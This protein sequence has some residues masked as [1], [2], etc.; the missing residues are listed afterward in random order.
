MRPENEGTF[1]QEDEDTL[2]QEE[3]DTL[4]NA[5]DRES[6]REN[7]K[8]QLFQVVTHRY[9]LAVDYADVERQCERFYAGGDFRIRSIKFI[10][11]KLI[12]GELPA[13]KI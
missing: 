8:L 4:L 5:A 12:T 13:I 11:G 3:I 6:K 9:V 1:G 2:A 10:S 7:Q